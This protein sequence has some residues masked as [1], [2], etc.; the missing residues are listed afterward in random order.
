MIELKIVTTT[1]DNIGTFLSQNTPR[2][3]ALLP[4]VGVFEL[5]HS[6][7]SNE[8]FQDC[9]TIACSVVRS[10]LTNHE[11]R[12]FAFSFFIF[13]RP[14]LPQNLTLENHVLF[15]SINVRDF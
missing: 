8:K 9:A 5:N 4:D 14:N 1:S 13:L 7:N 12:L 11:A 3:I 2:Q 6:T 15:S 10:R